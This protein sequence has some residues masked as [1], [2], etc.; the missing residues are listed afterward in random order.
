RPHRH[1]CK[2]HWRARSPTTL[3][4]LYTWCLYLCLSAGSYGSSW[5]QKS[6]EIVTSQ[7]S[8]HAKLT[9]PL[10][11]DGNV[12]ENWQNTVKPSLHQSMRLLPVWMPCR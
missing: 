5:C 1:C 11:F 6:A 8:C 4:L 7:R 3:A 12:A 9:N 10:I 2:Q